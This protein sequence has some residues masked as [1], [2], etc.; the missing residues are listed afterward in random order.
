VKRWYEHAFTVVMGHCGQYTILGNI[1]EG[2]H[3]I[4]FKAKH[5]EVRSLQSSETLVPD[6][7]E[8]G[9]GLELAI[10]FLSGLLPRRGRGAPI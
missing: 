1:G 10:R 9:I 3:G 5:I 4:V 8:L 7:S 6:S 2:A